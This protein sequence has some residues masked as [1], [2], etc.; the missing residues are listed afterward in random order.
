VT[1]RD[2]HAKALAI[3][4]DNLGVELRRAIADHLAT[5]GYEVRDFGCS[6][7][8][9]VDYPDVAV[10]VARAVAAAEFDRAILVCGTGVGMAIAANKIRGVRAASVADVY[11]AARAR[12]SNDAQILC[13][14]AR[15]VGTG[16]AIELVDRWLGAEF[17]GG[18]S[19][20]KVA[21]LEAL[22][23]LRAGGS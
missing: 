10:D 11:S 14:G 19:A 21:K 2:T 3:G 20:R 9:E 6:P 17:A 4:S 16:L 12:E 8:E 13:L 23:E 7:D 1:V 5:L 22:D 15:V 18:R